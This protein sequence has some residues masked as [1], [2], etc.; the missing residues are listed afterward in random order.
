MELRDVSLAKRGDVVFLVLNP[1]FPRTKTAHISLIHGLLREDS[2]VLTV[3]QR[4][5]STFIR[6]LLTFVDSC[7]LPEHS[8]RKVKVL[9]LGVFIFSWFFLMGYTL[10]IC[11]EDTA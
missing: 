6:D 4:V 1:R 8:F 11:L 7:F 2:G 3:V 10:A 9:F 5:R